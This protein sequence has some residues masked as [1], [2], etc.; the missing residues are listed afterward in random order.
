MSGLSFGLITGGSS[1][2]SLL[3]S[4]S[5]NSTLLSNN[6]ENAEASLLSNDT[7]AGT[8]AFSGKDIFGT[9]EFS[10]A[11]ANSLANESSETIGSCASTE[12]IGSVACASEAAGSVASSGS[13]SDCG[14][15]F[16]S[17]C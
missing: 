5:E 13:S 17:V 12:T 2:G 4:D 11:N 1:N 8:D 15:S 3:S 16:V 9:C 14:G 10:E 7:Q 6:T